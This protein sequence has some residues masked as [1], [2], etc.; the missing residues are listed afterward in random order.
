MRPPEG[1][2]RARCTGGDGAIALP[3]EHAR[4]THMHLKRYRVALV[5]MPLPLGL[6]APR[7]AA[8][9]A[10]A[11]FSVWHHPPHHVVAKCSFYKALYPGTMLFMAPFR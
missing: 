5:L 9:V 4:L 11:G 7:R 8:L 2:L 3:E 1:E 10:I 6:S